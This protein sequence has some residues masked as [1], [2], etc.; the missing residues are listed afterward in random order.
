M[1]RLNIKRNF[2]RSFNKNTIEFS[3][4]LVL[5]A[6]KAKCKEQTNNLSRK[7]LKK[8]RNTEVGGL[9][10]PGMKTYYKMITFQTV[11]VQEAGVRA[12]VF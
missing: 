5:V 6:Y 11:K 10:L 2:L 12:N 4:L 7:T 1:R 8:T 3:F 9:A